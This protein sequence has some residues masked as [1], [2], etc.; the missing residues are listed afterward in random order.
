MPSSVLVVGAGAA[1]VQVATT[2]RGRGFAGRVVLVGAEDGQPYHRP[3]LSKQQLT[4]PADPLPMRARSFWTQ[5]GIELLTGDPVTDLGLGAGRAVL[6]SGRTVGWD[7]VVL[8]TGA[9]ARPLPVPGGDRART[10]RTAAD[11]AALGAEL[12]TGAPRSVAVVGGGLLGLEIAAA[13]RGLGHDVAVVEVAPRLVARVVSAPCAE[14]L[15]ALHRH[16]G[17]ALHLGRT[18]TAVG[19]GDRSTRVRLDDGS[20]LAADVVVAALGAVPASGLAT[21]SGLLGG[22]GG[23]LVDAHLRTSDPRVYA[24]GDCAAAAPVPDGA[25]AARVETVQNADDQGRYAALHLLGEAADPYDEVPRGWTAQFGTTVQT[26]GAAPAGH[27][28]TVVLGEPSTGRFSVLRFAGERLGAVESVNSPA[29][30]AAARRMLG[31]GRPPTPL[32]ASR[33]G[34]A[35]A[36]PAA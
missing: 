14:H 3:P 21:A 8:A 22:A 27:D 30:H 15:G 26:V 20:T 23:V 16:H 32:Q 11:A 25:L 7:R 9:T 5:R 2:L 34:F 28:R 29:D 4:G 31:S 12:R 10:L 36:R 35:L 1:G 6:R 18:V 33:A 13:A 24:V 19:D 17:V